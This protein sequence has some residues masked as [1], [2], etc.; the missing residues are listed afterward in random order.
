MK[1]IYRFNFCNQLNDMTTTNFG[2]YWYYG[3]MP[4]KQVTHYSLEDIKKGVEGFIL[5]KGLFTKKYYIRLCGTFENTIKEEHFINAS[6]TK[7]PKAIIWNYSVGDLMEKLS[8]E[9]FV[10]WCKDKGVSICPNVK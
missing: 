7:E 9:D 6:C 8:A 5:D 3:E 10:E 4:E 2:S 1:V